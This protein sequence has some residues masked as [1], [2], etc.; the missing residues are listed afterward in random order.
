MFSTLRNTLKF[1]QVINNLCASIYV[2]NIIPV[3]LWLQK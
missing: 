3:I 1:E 2:V